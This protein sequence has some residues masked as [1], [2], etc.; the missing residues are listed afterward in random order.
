MFL[1][2]RLPSVTGEL[3]DAVIIE[4]E[5]LRLPESNR[6]LLADLLLESLSRVSVVQR[7]E[8]TSESTDRY[9]AYQQGKLQSVDG[10]EALAAMRKLFSK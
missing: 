8:W 6:A 10:P 3:M 5:A 7:G 9:E 2:D 4:S 1:W